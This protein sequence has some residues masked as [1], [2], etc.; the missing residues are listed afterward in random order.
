MTPS[1]DWAQVVAGLCS[2]GGGSS[3]QRWWLEALLQPSASRPALGHP[4]PLVLARRLRQRAPHAAQGVDA[5][6]GAIRRIRHRGLGHTRAIYI[7]CVGYPTTECLVRVSP[8]S[9]RC[10]ASA[11]DPLPLYYAENAGGARSPVA[12][13]NDCRVAKPGSLG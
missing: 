6:R 12:S 9:L 7:H 2:V 13:G 10:C 5:K 8:L 11:Q 1:G 3:A 4:I